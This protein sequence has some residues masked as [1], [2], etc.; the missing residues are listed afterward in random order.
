MAAGEKPADTEQAAARARYERDELLAISR[1]LSAERDIREL[2][3]LI[4]FKSR[5]ITGA[6]AG[7]VYVL[8][9]AEVEEPGPADSSNQPGPHAPMPREVLRRRSAA[10]GGGKSGSTTLH[11]MLSQNDSMA[12]DFQEFKL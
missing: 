4:L 7:S 2:L 3:D 8:E 11:F 1:A 9:A 12:V 10:L 5:Q 6:D